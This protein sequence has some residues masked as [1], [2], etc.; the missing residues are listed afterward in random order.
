MPAGQLWRLTI[1]A[2]GSFGCATLLISAGRSLASHCNVVFP[3]VHPPVDSRTNPNGGDLDRFPTSSNV[4]NHLPVESLR[5]CG[6]RRSLRRVAVAHP[7]QSFARC[8]TSG[9][10]ANRNLGIVATIKKNLCLF[11]SG[12]PGVKLVSCFLFRVCTVGAIVE[13]AGLSLTITK[14]V[15]RRVNIHL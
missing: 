3:P 15:F 8:A 6:A 14:I 1:L 9:S 4:S 11:T 7:G 10:A 2:L 5:R 13:A 12:L